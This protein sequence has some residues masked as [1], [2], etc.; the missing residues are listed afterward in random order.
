M[1]K[2]LEVMIKKVED[3]GKVTTIR[4]TGESAETWGKTVDGWS[5][6]MYAHGMQFPDL[7]W[8]NIDEPV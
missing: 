2:V 8:E 1:G 7:K 4:L 5:V 6:F 3:S